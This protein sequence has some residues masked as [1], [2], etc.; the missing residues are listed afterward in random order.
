[1]EVIGKEENGSQSGWELL[2]E[3]R[4]LNFPEIPLT[5]HGFPGKLNTLKNEFL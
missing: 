5:H 3:M 4:T 1:M 2:R